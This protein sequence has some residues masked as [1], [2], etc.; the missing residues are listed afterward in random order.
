MFYQCAEAL[1]CH[2]QYLVKQAT[3]CS[4]PSPASCRAYAFHSAK[5][6]IPHCVDF[7]VSG[8]SVE[9][10]I[11]VPLPHLAW[12]QTGNDWYSQ[13]HE[14][15]SV[16]SC[17]SWARSLYGAR[18]DLEHLNVGTRTVDKITNAQAK[19]TQFDGARL[20][21]QPL[22]PSESAHAA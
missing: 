19:A 2:D 3:F 22:M 5:N 17:L 6:F 20:R 14:E 9:H 4:E 1:L 8:T 10:R 18:Y 12:K 15:L 13:Y 7:S 16:S 11:A 21:Q